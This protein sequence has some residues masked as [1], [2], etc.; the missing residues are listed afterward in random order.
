M[1]FLKSKL[2]LLQL[3]NCVDRNVGSRYKKRTIVHNRRSME[4]SRRRAET[5]Y[6]V[7]IIF[8]VQPA[9]CSRGNLILYQ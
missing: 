9:A 7:S 4:F 1:L 3:L 8:T 6:V 5:L 2:E